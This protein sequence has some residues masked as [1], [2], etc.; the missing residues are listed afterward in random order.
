[1]EVRALENV[2]VLDHPLIKHKLSKLRDRE[3]STP[4]FRRLLRE[5]AMLMGYEVTRD[6]PLTVKRI[7]TPMGPM[8]APVIEGEEVAVVPILRAGLGMADGLLELL[9]T[10]LV[11][12]IGVYRDAVTHLPHEYYAKLPKPAGGIYILVDPMLATGNS[13]IHAVDVMN[14]MGVADAHIRFMVLVAAPEGIENFHRRHPDVPIYVAAVDERL[15]DKAY[16]LP[17]LG[18][19]GDRI[20]GTE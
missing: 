11:G 13:A 16:I 5:V 4:A 9:P 17:G 12:H 7:E 2:T 20:F 1:M 15:D 19:A 18:D 6:L 3:T 10:A 14:A 8:E